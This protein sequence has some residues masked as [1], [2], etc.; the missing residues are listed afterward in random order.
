MKLLNIIVPRAAFLN[1]YLFEF[2]FEVKL[3][4]DFDVYV[5]CNSRISYIL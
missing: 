3:G 2:L 4:L 5:S 1:S